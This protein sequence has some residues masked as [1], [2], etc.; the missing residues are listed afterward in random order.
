VT[1]RD[2]IL[3]GSRNARDGRAVAWRLFVNI[4]VDIARGAAAAVGLGLALVA[5]AGEAEMA[6]RAP[7][8]PQRG[9]P[10]CVAAPVEDS[11]PRE[12]ARSEENGAYDTRRAPSID[13]G[14]IGDAPLGRNPA[15]PHRVPE[16]QKPFPCHWTHTCVPVASPWAM[17]Y[18][19]PSVGE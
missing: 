6:E 19:G 2:G 7:A 1:S 5:C 16:W 13:L 15:P 14:A 9:D 11:F 17:P 8:T 18:Q 10:S 4:A 12:F 3:Q